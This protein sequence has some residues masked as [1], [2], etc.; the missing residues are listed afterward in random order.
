MNIKNI[1]LKLVSFFFALVL[2]TTLICQPCFAADEKLPEI[3]YAS[4]VCLYSVNA[5]KLVFKHS[6]NK[7]MFPAGSAKMMAGIIA[8][9]LLADRLDEKVLITADMLEG[10]EGINVRLKEGMSVTVEELLLGLLCGGGNDAAIVLS[11]ICSESPEAFVELMNDK[12][13]EWGLLSTNFT[14]PTGLDDKKMSTSLSDILLLAKRASE[15]ELY[16]RFSSMPYFTY[17]NTTGSELKIYN[18]NSLISTYYADGYKNSNVKGLMTSFTDLGG[19]SAMIYAE[20][21]DDAYICIVMG[22]QKHNGTIY[23]FEYA[24]I[25]LSYAFNNLKYDKVLTS[26]TDICYADVEFAAPDNGKDVARVLCVASQDAYAL[27]P[28]DIDVE[29]DLEYRYYLHYDT[30]QAPISENTVIGGVDVIYDGEVIATSKLVTKE[31]LEANG[32]ILFMHKARSFIGSRTFIICACLVVI[33]LLVYF[34]IFLLKTRR[35]TVKNIQYKNF[36]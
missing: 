9:E 14:N 16:V 3:K 19:Y 34:Y 28:K 25:L 17:S 1:S 11:K 32:L 22:A 18:R 35:R 24:N 29:S 21:G 15:N 27:I 36:Y 6:E 31:R 10:T 2:V 20:R 13:D 26:G 7:K 30:L 33:S 4:D 23:S 8:C 12:C 5:D